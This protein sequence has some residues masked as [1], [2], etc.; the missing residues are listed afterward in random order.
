MDRFAHYEWPFFEVT[1]RGLAREV[2]KFAKESLAACA[3]RGR[4]CDL[5]ALVQD[6]GC[7]GFLRHCVSEKPDVRSIAI[8]RSARLP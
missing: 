1:H 6:L 7:S 2:E 3:R 4:R 5:Q 8:A